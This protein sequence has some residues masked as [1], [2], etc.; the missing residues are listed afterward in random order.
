MSQDLPTGQENEL[1]RLP[2]WLRDMDGAEET[3][4]WLRQLAQKQEEFPEEGVS[5]TLDQ[6]PAGEPDWLGD[7]RGDFAAEAPEEEQAVPEGEAGELPDW[8]TDVGDEAAESEGGAAVPDWLSGFG[9]EAVQPAQGA[10]DVF[11]GAPEGALPDWLAGFGETEAP[12]MILEEPQPEESEAEAPAW[13]RGVE[14]V[15][16]QDLVDE[17]QIPTSEALPDWLLGDKSQI[18]LEPES[19]QPESEVPEWL[20]GVSELPQQPELEA[21]AGLP[22]WLSGIAEESV[23]PGAPAIEEPL[24]T[25]D[26]LSGAAGEVEPTES[27]EQA[28]LP[29]WLSGIAEESVEPEPAAELAEPSEVEGTLPDWLQAIRDQ[30]GEPE[31]P[32]IEESLETPDWLLSA[33]IEKGETGE[34]GSVPDWL[35]QIEFEDAQL[36]L[37]GEATSEVPETEEALPD[38]LGI[39]EPEEAELSKEATLELGFNVDETV[40]KLPD[41]FQDLGETSSEGKVQVPG[42]EWLREIESAPVPQ[43]SLFEEEPSDVIPTPDWLDDL[44]LDESV[45]AETS[46][47]APE[48]LGLPSWLQEADLGERVQEKSSLDSILSLDK[49]AGE[50]VSPELAELE[51]DIRAIA[52]ET[53][54]GS[55]IGSGLD[56]WIE[57]QRT[58]V[59]PVT[60][61]TLSVETSGPLA[62]L[63]GLLAPEPL[64]GIFPKSVYKPAQPIPDAHVAEAQLFESILSA[65][66]GEPV[67]VERTQ[68]KEALASLGRWVIYLALLATM[69]AAAFLPKPFNELIRAPAMDE[70]SDFYNAIQR[71][72][73][74]SVALLALDYDAALDGELTPQTRAIVRHLSQRGVGVAAVSITPQGI[75]IVQD[76][77]A[78]EAGLVAGE[79]YLNLGYLPPHPASLQALIDG[80]VNAPVLGLQARP[81]ETPLGQKMAGLEQVDLVVTVSGSAD[82]VRWWVEQVGSRY[83]ID[84][85]AGVSAAIAPYVLPYYAS[86]YGQIKGLV[87]GLAGAADYEQKLVGGTPLDYAQRNLVLQGYGQ[88]VLAAILLLSGITFVLRKRA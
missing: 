2:D 52:A 62:G 17:S 87:I 35:Q 74:G 31:E 60:D 76:V 73:E 8:F 67:V 46:S 14:P 28:G 85:V 81:E 36:S 43:E 24:E 41:W 21:K 19:V 9:T 68:G 78:Q 4:D 7:F 20:H 47:E 13:L 30:T 56:T 63:R 70:T 65:P 29:D 27:E 15:T 55:G 12:Q 1:N 64:L 84:I 80:P 42:T 88:L 83:G 39:G 61:Q 53:G 71:L 6:E 26:W 11:E 37:S 50:P 57:E 3:P 58:R 48:A 40:P 44:G 16:P 59:E 72:P 69:V 23:E 79:D 77:F 66:A 10:G 45:Q 33:E 25:P 5:A 22:D 49:V 34:E 18:V 51:Q 82:H 75:A 86:D 38:W 54:L 32:E